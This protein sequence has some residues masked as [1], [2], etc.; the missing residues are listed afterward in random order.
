ME[1]VAGEQIY[2]LGYALGS[3]TGLLNHLL[4]RPLARHRKMMRKAT[5][6]F[7][8]QQDDLLLR[9]ETTVRDFATSDSNRA[10]HK[11]FY[12]NIGVLSK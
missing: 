7:R 12:S 5:G 1:L 2:P 9:L 11:H 8:W 4:V 3:H 10:P 6:E